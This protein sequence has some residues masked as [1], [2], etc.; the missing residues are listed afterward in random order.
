M[1]EDE[2]GNSYAVV[3]IHIAGQ[4]GQG[5]IGHADRD[6]RHVLERIRHGEQKDVH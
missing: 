2:I 1:A 4:R 3:L 6:R 5:A